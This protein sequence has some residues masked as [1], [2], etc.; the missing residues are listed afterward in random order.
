[1][2]GNFSQ[3]YQ[4]GTRLKIDDGNKET[5]QSANIFGTINSDDL[6]WE[7]NCAEL[8]RKA[9]ARMSLLRKSAELGSS[10]EDKKTVYIFF[11]SVC[12][13]SQQLFGGRLYHWKTK[14]TW[15][16]VKESQ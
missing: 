7:L 5:V 13:S 11:C 12:W 8:V 10:E 6:S 1:M 15:N 16:N 14:K 2:I 4:F 3:K 9:N